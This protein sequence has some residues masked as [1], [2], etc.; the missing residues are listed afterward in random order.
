MA[1][2]IDVTVALSMNKSGVN[3]SRS[4]G[5][6]VTMSGDA[7]F[8]GV[9]SIAEDAATALEYVDL[10]AM[11]DD[12]GDAGDTAGWI[13]LKNLDSTN[14]VK[15]G[16]SGEYSF[17]LLAGESCVV[18]QIA[19]APLYGRADTAACNIEMLVIET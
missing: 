17:R 14:F 9:Q 16:L 15:F 8:H 5:F 10:N 3:T 4:E 1:N 2:E 18:R 13:F 12:V 6:K 7:I 11:G 19:S